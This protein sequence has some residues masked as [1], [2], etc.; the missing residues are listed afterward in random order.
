MADDLH[1]AAAT[2]IGDEDAPGSRW[3]R[4][5]RSNGM[6][7]PIDDRFTPR[8][9]AR[10]LRNGAYEPREYRAVT[11]LA[12]PEDIVLELGAGIGYMSTTCATKNKCA[13]IHAFEAN[14][15]LIPYIEEV[16]RQNGVTTAKITNAVLGP[17]NG[18]A[19]FY[20]RTEFSSSSLS[21]DPGAK[22]LPVIDVQ[23]V[24]MLSIAET[25]RRIK[26]T[27][28]ICDIEG[29]EATLIPEADLSSVRCAV[30]ELHPQWIGKDGTAA[31]FDAFR[32]AGLVFFPRTSNKKVVTF[33]KDW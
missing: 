5:L 24:P 21:E 33:R 25:F 1:A 3:P 29:A 8:R 15:E 13:E 4:R 19:K 11:A 6:L 20:I 9:Q 26:P 12:R 31:V 7:F 30:V 22:A 18:T 17:T 32:A 14:P 10:A 23:D 16:Y 28:F 27:F 2:D